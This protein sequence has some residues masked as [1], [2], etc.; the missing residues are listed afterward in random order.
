MTGAS[1]PALLQVA[2]LTHSDPGFIGTMIR[3]D[4]THKPATLVMIFVVAEPFPPRVRPK[5]TLR[6]RTHTIT[7]LGD[8][9]SPGASISIPLDVTAQIQ[10][11]WRDVSDVF[12]Q[13]SIKP[14]RCMASSA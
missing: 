9:I 4:A 3:C 10:S 11:A 13:I 1:I 6:N 5:V 12:V 2:D 7:F 14:R 8:V